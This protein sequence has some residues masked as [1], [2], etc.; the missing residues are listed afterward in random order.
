MSCVRFLPLLFALAL[1]CVQ[2]FADPKDPTSYKVKLLN[3][4]QPFKAKLT[5]VNTANHTLT[6]EV[7]H[8]GTEPDPQRAT[9]IV[10]LQRQIVAARQLRDFQSAYRLQTELS[11]L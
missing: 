7:K 10:N 5:A 2:V 1:L 11:K 6:I 8:K 4:T 3:S 9:D